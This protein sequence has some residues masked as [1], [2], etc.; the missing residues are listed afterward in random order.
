MPKKRLLIR[1]PCFK[2]FGSQNIYLGPDY[3]DTMY[4]SK[5][6]NHNLFIPKQLYSLDG[7]YELFE[8]LTQS[9]GKEVN[10]IFWDNANNF[11]SN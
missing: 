6:Y 8:I 2:L 1:N 10:N 7:F 11:F 3:F 5:V 4:F 9:I